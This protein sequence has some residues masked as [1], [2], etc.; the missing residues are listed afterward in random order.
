MRRERVWAWQVLG[1]MGLLAGHARG[2]A[3]PA[4]LEM[5]AGS[6]VVDVSGLPVLRPGAPVA[7]VRPGGQT[8]TGRGFVL[9]VKEERALVGLAP[10]GHVAVSDHV[11]LCGQNAD[12]E[13]Y[14]AL[15][16]AAESLRRDAGD[17][18]API[19]APAEALQAALSERDAAV[20]AG[21][22]DTSA[23]DQQLETLAQQIQSKLEHVSGPDPPT[24]SG[25]DGS[26]SDPTGAASEP[27]VA[28]EASS[29][30]P[31]DRPAQKVDKASRVVDTMTRLVELGLKIRSEV[32]GN[33]SSSPPAGP[34]APGADPAEGTGDVS[35]T[36]AGM[37]SGSPPSTTDAP[38]HPPTGGR[39][40]LPRLPGKDA[41]PPQTTA[42]HGGMRVPMLA[43]TSTPGPHAPAGSHLRIPR[44]P[45]PAA[46]GPRATVAIEAEALLP[47]ARVSGGGSVSKQSMKSFGAGWGGDAQLVWHAA[48]SVGPFPLVKLVGPRRLTLR[49]NVPRP[50]T[51][52]I[53][54]EHTVASDYANARLS[55]DGTFRAELR[56]YAPAVGHRTLSLGRAPLAAGSHELALEVIGKDQASAGSFVG[57]DRIELE[58]TDMKE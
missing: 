20:E 50:G 29:Q 8:E 53:L 23:F 13:Q 26:P 57:L 55:L 54:L 7:F 36:A 58:P 41:P 48:R 14:R 4:V 33:A 42:G 17:R 6:A 19:A 27:S 22:C 46:G 30:P 51:Y 40:Q 5:R 47:N 32:H 49:F 25:V 28:A 1:L 12:A 38:S 44:L 21:R 24:G 18:A 52:Q 43:G 45:L 31:M 11:V 2:Q 15:A 34:S 37:D 9:E 56:G 39:L 3:L 10:G 16:K 35:D